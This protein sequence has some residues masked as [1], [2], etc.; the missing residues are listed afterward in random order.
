N[1]GDMVTGVGVYRGQHAEIFLH[2][3]DEQ[4]D[5][6]VE[7]YPRREGITTHAIGG[8]HDLVFKK[9]IGADPL[10]AIADRRDDIE[11]LGQYSAWVELTPNFTLYLIHP[12][13]SQAYAVSYKLQKLV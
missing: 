10:K 11:H 1:G 9:S 4:V 5:Y 13:G 3:Y 12:A 6:T 8:N 2:T 7:N